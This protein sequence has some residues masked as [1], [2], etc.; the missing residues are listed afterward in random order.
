M[1]QLRILDD[2][3]VRRLLDGAAALRLDAEAFRDHG[4]K[5]SFLSAPSSLVVKGPPA[6]GFRLLALPMLTHNGHSSL[7]RLRHQPHI[8]SRPQGGGEFFYFIRS[9]GRGVS[10]AALRPRLLALLFRHH[11]GPEMVILGHRPHTVGNLIP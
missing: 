9:A 8:Q 7:V 2:T 3:D 6:T 1:G 11:E 5:Q 10:C 4:L